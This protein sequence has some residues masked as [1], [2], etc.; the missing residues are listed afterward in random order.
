MGAAVTNQ[1]ER[2]EHDPTTFVGVMP[3]GSLV[4]VGLASRADFDRIDLPARDHGETADGHLLSKRAGDYRT[5][6]VTVVF[7]YWLKSK[8]LEALLA[9]AEHRRRQKAVA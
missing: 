2:L 7:Q 5:G 8:T 6:E 3:D 1:A 4:Y 9:D